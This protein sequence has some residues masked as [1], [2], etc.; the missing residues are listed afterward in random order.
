MICLTLPQ[1]HR[2]SLPPKVND[3][4]GSKFYY[5]LNFSVLQDQA[6]QADLL[7]GLENLQRENKTL[8]RKF[9]Y[10]REAA[11]LARRA[12]LIGE[13]KIR[14][15]NELLQES[16]QAADVSVQEHSQLLIKL[17]ELQKWTDSIDDDDAVRVMR[18]L[19]QRLEDWIKRHYSQPRAAHPTRDNSCDLAFSR[20]NESYC[21]IQT[22]QGFISEQIFQVILSRFMVGIRDRSLENLFYA[23]DTEVRRTC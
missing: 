4:R 18:R 8:Q 15:Q 13:E 10:A 2:M 16:R 1:E 12:Q 7:A 23:M 5:M 21:T 19:F 11:T 17:N 6:D 14:R 3:P 20:M 22:I 9:E